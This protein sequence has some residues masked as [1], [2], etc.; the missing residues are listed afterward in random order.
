MIWEELSTNKQAQLIEYQYI[1]KFVEIYENKK[2]ASVYSKL[3]KAIDFTK[4]PPEDMPRDI[5]EGDKYYLSC[6][7]LKRSRMILY[8]NEITY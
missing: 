7:L 5:I 4:T 2:A 6:E 1:T 8:D 3:V